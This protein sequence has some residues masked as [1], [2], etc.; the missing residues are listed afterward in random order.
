MGETCEMKRKK[1]TLGGCPHSSCLCMPRERLFLLI[2]KSIALEL[3]N[4]VCLEKGLR[5]SSCKNRS[6]DIALLSRRC[7]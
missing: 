4:P 6:E 5:V 1:E 3:S 2:E 7:K